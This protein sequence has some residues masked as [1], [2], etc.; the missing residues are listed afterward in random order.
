MD[1]HATA[2]RPLDM[3]AHV[4]ECLQRTEA[5]LSL[6][7]TVHLCH[8]IGQRAQ[9]DCAMGDGLVPGYAY[10]ALQAAAGPDPVNEIML[11]LCRD[12]RCHVSLRRLGRL[13]TV[14]GQ[15]DFT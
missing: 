8:T 11:F 1:D 6:E 13:A 12:G 14:E 2:A 15:K 3:H 9:H 7:E 4:T 10:I 5:V